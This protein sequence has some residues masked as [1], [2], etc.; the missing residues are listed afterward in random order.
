MTRA[1]RALLARPGF[2]IVAVATLALGLGVNAAIFSLTRTVLLR[3]LPYADADRIVQVGEANRSRGVA[4]SPT[5][6]ANYVDWRPRV[7]A[8]ESTA[9]WRVVSF[10]IS[11][12]G[13]RPLRAM[14]VLAEPE[15]FPILGTAPQP[16]R[17]FAP[18]EAR[19]GRDNVVLLGRSF[20]RREFGADPAVVGRTLVVDGAPCTIVGVLPES[21]KFFHVLNRELDL[22]RPF[23]VDPAD[24][25]HSVT[26][27]AKLRRG[28]ALESARAELATAFDALPAERFRD[29]WTADAAPL[30]ARFTANQRPI[31]RALEIAVA[32]VMCIAA[33]NISNLVLA[34]AAG[35]RKD[36]AVRVALGATPW[37]L[38]TELGR[39]TLLLGAAG[40]TTGLLLAIWIVDLLNTSISYQDINRL[41]P[42]RVD[43]VV[44]AFT[45]ALAAVSATIFALL[46]ARGVASA[47][48][49]DALKDSSPGVTTGVANRRLRSALVVGEL[50][51]SIVL[52]TSALQLTARALS[53]NDMDRGVDVDRV[54]TAQVA[55]NAPRYGEPVGLTQ[56][57]DAVLARLAASPGIA[58]ASIVNYPP[59]HV[60]GTSFP[61]A[62]E[63]RAD[64]PGREP[65]ALCWTVAPRYFETV[66]IPV[67]A[68]RDFTPGD[69]RDS[70]G[71]VIVSRQLA[72]RF[73][74]RSEVLG[75]RLTV[76][77]PESGAFWIPRVIRRPLTI[78]GVVGDVREDGIA[79]AGASDPQ[80]YL[81]YS[82]GPTRVLALVVRM[83]GAPAGA[84]PL[85]RDAVRAVDPA[86]PTFDE[87]TLD[88]VRSE[89]FARPRE[90]A[91]LIG[92]FAALALAL[93]AIGVYGVIAYLTTARR[94]EIAIRMAL[95]ATRRDVVALIVG[96]SLKLTG[97]G[98]AIGCIATPIASRLASAS[99]P[100]VSGWSPLALA[101]VAAVL[102]GVSVAAAT[103]PAYRAARADEAVALRSA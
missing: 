33:A 77:V 70:Q 93:S 29:G 63:G 103:I 79:D 26:V 42:F 46:P 59:L 14:G 39:E 95:G 32:L 12:H 47:D 8:F 5:V 34:V 92:T 90:I 21:F 38:A 49:V 73:W 4:Y 36:V 37:Q 23:T 43:P 54:M 86:Q 18:E 74:G 16:G 2:T 60:I 97:F 62:V 45:L 10:T 19:P 1:L 13:D 67:R 41:E 6:P 98:V 101:E 65:R 71:V 57:A 99:L 56:F 100:G 89:T 50:A 85:V 30:L 22:W 44:A 78:V 11:G 48:V 3:P 82:Q 31:L 51:L 40:A 28:A 69:T 64:A 53:L 96:D 35:R 68:G 17:Q 58:S 88:D 91:W 102:A 81:P 72:Q 83:H 84:A 87:K 25:E 24:R 76:L 55:L 20:W 94:R 15:F 66:G 7:T 27:Y 52:L 61:I 80:L 75:E 9:A